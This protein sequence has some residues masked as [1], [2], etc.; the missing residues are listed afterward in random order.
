MS[1]D[2]DKIF[3]FSRV[4]IQGYLDN[5]HERTH[6]KGIGSGFLTE[7]NS[8]FSSLI[9]RQTTLA[10]G[11]AESPQSWNPHIAPLFLRP[12]IECLIMLRWIRVEPIGRSKEYINFGLGSEKLL[13]H[14]Y[15]KAVSEEGNNGFREHIESIAEYSLA[16]VE[17]QQFQQFVEVNLGSWAG[18]SVR[19][20]AQET[21]SESL[22]NFAYVPFSANLH[23]Q[24]N[25]VGKFN[26]TQC[27]NPMH[28]QHYVGSIFEI[29]F[30]IDFVYRSV[31]YLGLAFAEFDELFDFQAK[32]VPVSDIFDVAYEE[33]MERT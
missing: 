5:L 13:A 19:K 14:H 21:D 15:Q 28:K 27:A 11:L 1:D 33:L 22:Y 18:Q 29:D 12:M 8:T 25:H 32:T 3:R 17:S 31:K 9:A 23:N 26:A 24:W 20:M 30:V 2:L 4:L 7:V 16:W 10:L 6:S